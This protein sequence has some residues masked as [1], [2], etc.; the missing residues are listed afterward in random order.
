MLSHACYVNIDSGISAP[1]HDREV[2]DGL[3]PIEKR[4]QL[5][6]MS[7]VKLPGENSYDTWMATQT[8]IYTF[9]VSL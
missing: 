3:N 1:G 2:L 8:G 6:L 5:Q 4:F 9:N 7:T